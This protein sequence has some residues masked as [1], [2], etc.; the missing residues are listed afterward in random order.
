M[1]QY[2]SSHFLELTMY[3]PGRRQ[4]KMLL[5]IDEHGSKLIETVLSIAIC[6]QSGD[7]WQLKTLLLKIFDLCSSI[8]LTFLIATYPV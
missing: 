8:V 4:L 6:H 1:N 7:K 2:D 3:T 5:T